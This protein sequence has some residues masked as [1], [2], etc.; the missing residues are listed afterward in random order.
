[1]GMD[2][3]LK[4]VKNQKNT[5]KRRAASFPYINSPLFLSLSLYI[6]RKRKSDL[7]Y[8]LILIDRSIYTPILPIS[9]VAFLFL[10]RERTKIKGKGVKNLNRQRP[11]KA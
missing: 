6:P 4:S 1:M 5:K 7:T 8:L 2:G 11:G 10:Y 9:F 3:G